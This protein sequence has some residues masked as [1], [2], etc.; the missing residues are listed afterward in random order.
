MSFSQSTEKE[1]YNYVQFYIHVELIRTLPVLFVKREDQHIHHYYQEYL[2]CYMY[3][4][5]DSNWHPT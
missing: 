4:V 5:G 3:S 2:H 1:N